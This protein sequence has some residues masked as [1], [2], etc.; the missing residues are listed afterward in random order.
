[1]R[2]I[3]ILS[4]LL[5]V[6]I[7]ALWI[8]LT[9][10]GQN[11]PAISLKPHFR[12]RPGFSVEEVYSPEKSGSVV[13]MTFD[14]QGRLVISREKG[15][16]VTLLDLNGD[17][18]P[19]SEQIF[20]DKVTNCQG[21]C[22]DGN[23][24]FAV[25]DGPR[26]PGLYRVTDEDGDGKGDTVSTLELFTKE[27]GEHGPHA[28]LFG[29]DGLLHVVLGNHTGLVSTPDFFSPYKDY[30]EGQLLPIFTDP[31]GHAVNVRAPGG[32]IVRLVLETPR[33]D[34]SISE[35]YRWQ[36]F[37]GGFRNTYDAA[38]NL[39]GELFTF[40]SDMEW[41][42]NLPWYRPV[43]THHLIPGGDQGWR[44]GSGVWPAY[45]VD[46]LPSMTDI[47]RGS[48][49]GVT[50]Y[51][52]T[53]YP[54]EYYDSFI[55]GD[56][57]R[58]RILVSFLKKSGAT[59]EEKTE[60]FVLGEPLNVTDLEVGPDGFLYFSKG[61]RF[62]EGGI[63]RVAYGTESSDSSARREGKGPDKSRSRGKKE[64]R[65]STAT[66]A[67]AQPETRN[68]KPETVDRTR[69]V[70]ALPQ[71]AMGNPQS[72][73]DL[74]LTQP[75]PRSSWARARLRKIRELA[76]TEW[77]R[78]LLETAKDTAVL[79]ERRVRALELIEVYG[80]EA[81]T[82][83][84]ASQSIPDEAPL[85]S[86]GNDP[87]WEVRAA[88][89]YYLGLHPTES[90][91]RELARRLHDSDPF[92]PRRACEALIR[93]EIH[94]AM[95]IPFSPV[96]DIFPLLE[97]PDRY[98]RYAARQVLRRVNRNMWR[99][100]A[101]KLDKYPAVTEG[102]L[103]LVQ[104]VQG[105]NDVQYLLA[106]EL[107]LLNAKPR[108]E[109]L[110][111]LL[112]VIHLTMIGDEGVDYSKIYDSMGELLLGRFPSK[113][114]ASRTPGATL[115][116]V[117]ALNR[118]IARTLARL[119]TPG[120]IDKILQELS[121]PKLDREQQILYAHFLRAIQHGWEPKQRG[122]FVQWF[123]KTQEEHWKGGASFLGY[124]EDIW[125]DFLK[126]VPPPEKQAAMGRV[127]SLSPEISKPEEKPKRAFRRLQENQILSDQELSEFLLWDPMSYTGDIAAGKLA[128]EKAYCANCHRLG[129]MGKDAGPDLTDVGKRFTRKDIVEAIIYPSKTISDQ[130]VAVE[131]VTKDDQSTIG[132]IKR[133]DSKSVTMITAD[134]SEVTIPKSTI[135]S[136]SISKISLMP[137]GLLDNLNQ[138][139]TT[140]LF[141]FLEQR[142][143]RTEKMKTQREEQKQKRQQQKKAEK[144]G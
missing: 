95:S 89:T 125:N 139:E 58:G 97:S 37:T 105:T 130:Y 71:A 15:P 35:S 25:G 59:Y 131:V 26:G 111:G 41:D 18:L 115:S 86:L 12:T 83:E 79:P 4:I 48:P 142:T 51:Q 82:A 129:D 135:R 7:C 45:Y 53:V 30:A 126:V 28:V 8:G 117:Q 72:L 68:P 36:V 98:L 109:D 49:T 136:R 13:A 43:R 87:Q 127:P 40:D 124:I 100:E 16:V 93:T 62:T 92:V 85:T 20:T 103:A 22:F 74:A 65:R 5:L 112:R 81:K 102:L 101:L 6:P 137:E 27:M 80:A 63:Y 70:L 33:P 39:M 1:M 21:L 110:L 91:R 54:K 55:L 104:T 50:F 60:E 56:W 29:P 67:P 3:L 11:P 69:D 143:K 34:A 2:R 14:S 31:R 78:R 144:I 119:E 138:Q 94:P 108:D 84:T 46:S 113:E 76:G 19:D 47:G 77:P 24:L 132:I 106:R 57:S 64:K 122:A 99:D 118:E 42:I 107:E 38:F 66:A 96:R 141:A 75:Q 116:T 121:N 61:G 23:D 73:I 123:E 90:A 140:D 9:A 128:Y 133:E 52:H 44:T 10:Q 120:A 114:S 134:G 88:S 32:T 17:G